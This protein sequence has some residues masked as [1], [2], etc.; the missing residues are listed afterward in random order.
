VRNS[1]LSAMML[2]TGCVTMLL[3]S[4][5]PGIGQD[6]PPK[7]GPGKGSL[8]GGGKGK[9][10]A[11][12]AG[13]VRRLP[14]GKPDLQGR[15]TAQFGNALFSFSTQGGKKGPV[16]DPPDGV[17]PY[18]PEAL[19]KAKDLAANK[20][21][22]EPEAHCYMSGVPHQNY[23]QFGFQIVQNPTY[24][25]M[26]WEFMHSYRIIPTDGRPHAVPKD[27][28]LFNGDST[29]HWE[30]DTLVV[31]VTNQT[32]KTWYD[33]AGNFQS[34]KVHVIEKFIPVDENTINYEAVIEDPEVY[35]Q[36]IKIAGVFRRAPWEELMEF[37]CIEGND[38]L[39]H[40]TEDQ[41]G[42]KKKVR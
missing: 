9:A 40:Y 8:P 39:N 32:G 20:M 35:T 1:F 34:D 13:P 4:Q 25:V 26:L 15:W 19:A 18:K 21:F 24:M 5:M 31:D 37:G 36:P 10:P 16:I 30:G 22:L 38:D 11:P 3:V 6:G 23:V 33:L 27:A 28:K 12:P 7:G 42:T 41:G 2:A 17:L 14:N 29:G